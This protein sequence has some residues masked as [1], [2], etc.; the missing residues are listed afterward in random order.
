MA[1][2]QRTRSARL[3][4]VTLVAASLAIITVDYRGG[5]DGP[6]DSVGEAISSALAALGR[7]GVPVYVLYRPGRPPVVLSELLGVDELRQAVARL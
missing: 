7:N 6:L 5:D 4:V 2:R 1:I 3:L